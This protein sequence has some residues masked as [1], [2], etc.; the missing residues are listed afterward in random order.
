MAL[1]GDDYRRL[2]FSLLPPG[3]AW[4]SAADSNFQRLLAGLAKEPARVDDR[5]EK[6]LAEAD[7]RTAD[8]L[9]PEWEQSF[10]LPDEC[11][12]DDQSTADRRATL[13]GRVVG[14][15]GMRPQD[16]VDIADGLGYEGLEV[17]EQRE[18]TMELGSGAGARGAEIGDPLNDEDWLYAWDALISSDVVREAV[19]DDSEI[20]DP[21]RSWGDSLIECVLH[22][23]APSWLYLN[24]GYKEE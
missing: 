3:M 18:A 6:L 4:P 8:A 7:P 12:A 11:M 23:A 2:L 16:Y 17:V 5:I 10:G 21:L 20:G 14:R 15:G 1:T 22:R 13:L 24:V 9:F 19:I